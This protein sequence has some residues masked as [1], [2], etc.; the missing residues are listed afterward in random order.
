MKSLLK[1][2]AAPRVKLKQENGYQ[3]PGAK[4]IKTEPASSAVKREPEEEAKEEGDG[5][6]GLLCQC[7]ASFLREKGDC[8]Q[9]CHFKTKAI[10]T[11]NFEVC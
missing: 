6:A 3:A 7:F 9:F 4:R 5:L 11:H 8:E 10:G 2:K 1:V